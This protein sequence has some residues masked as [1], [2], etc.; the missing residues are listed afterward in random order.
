M[1][2]TEFVELA[3]LI[4][5][6]KHDFNSLTQRQKEDLLSE[7]ARLE[8]DIGD[9]D[10]ANEI[11]RLVPIPAGMAKGIKDSFGELGV[12]M[13]KEIDFNYSEEEALHGKDWLEK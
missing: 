5:L 2:T 6:A 12:E 7:A 10:A 4:E 11:F 8:F 3:D 9:E 13:L 1:T